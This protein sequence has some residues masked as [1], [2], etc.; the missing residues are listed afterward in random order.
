METPEAK[1]IAA[2]LKCPSGEDGL[3]TAR[4]MNENNAGVIRET[5]QRLKPADHDKVLEIGPG[6]A[7]HLASL[8]DMAGSL[9]YTGIDISATMVEQAT[10]LNAAFAGQAD[11]RLGDGVTLPFDPATFDKIFTVN[12]FYFWPDPAQQLAEIKRV[13]KPGGRFIIAMGS[14]R[15]MENLPFTQFEFKLYNEPEVEAL[16]KEQGFIVQ[17]TDF[18]FEPG[19]EGM[20]KEFMIFTI[21]KE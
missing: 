6:N 1:Y 13:L 19:P 20:Q 14:K 4:K 16:L 12:T 3:V 9:S 21:T 15:F 18:Y 11:F 5:L 10:R 8:L 17:Q 2:Q 7:S